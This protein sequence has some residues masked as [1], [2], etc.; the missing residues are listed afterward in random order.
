M[1]RSPRGVK[2]TTVSVLA[3]VF[4]CGL[5]VRASVPTVT[6]GNWFVTGALGAIPPGAA[7]VGLPDG[8]L[9][10]SGG[11]PVA[12][13]PTNQIKIFDPKVD[14]WT[15]VGLMLTPRSG[16][17]ATLLQDGR[18]AF[19]GGMTPNGGQAAF[20]VE[21]FDPANGQRS[22]V[23]YMQAPHTDH[24]A[25]VLRDGR[26]LIVGGTYDGFNPITVTE[27]L[28]VT[29]GQRISLTPPVSGYRIKA[30]ATTL[31]DGRVLIA[32]G[33]YPGGGAEIVF[34]EIFD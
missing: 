16:H 32:G 22:I 15:S 19:A 6:S 23:G 29:N 21:A 33:K 5:L 3:I 30:T 10:V 7:A 17:T 31:M 18:V 25:A 1:T 34:N 13:V 26:L 9:L 24:A 2:L 14:A 12:G 11:S 4:A 8:R 28:D 27:I 20:D